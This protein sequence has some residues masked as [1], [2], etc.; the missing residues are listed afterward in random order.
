MDYLAKVKELVDPEKVDSVREFILNLPS[1][2]SLSLT[3]LRE[4]VGCKPEGLDQVLVAMLFENEVRIEV[5][6]CDL[7]T[8]EPVGPQV[9]DMSLIRQE[10]LKEG[11]THD[12]ITYL[13]HFFTKGA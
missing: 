5:T 1:D 11:Y 9:K 2:T 10:D 13:V 12:N 4:R 3:D 6:P 8:L 7:D